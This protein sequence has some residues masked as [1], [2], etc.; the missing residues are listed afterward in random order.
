VRQRGAGEISRDEFFE[1]LSKLQVSGWAGGS[2]V[3][4][5]S[6]QSVPSAAPLAP[7]SATPQL[8]GVDVLGTSVGGH[9]GTLGEPDP[10]PSAPWLAGASPLLTGE[11]ARALLVQGD[12]A[13]KLSAG[14]SGPLLEVSTVLP[15]GPPL[16]RAA[17]GSPADA[18]TTAASAAA[19]A[20]ARA[21][22]CPVPSTQQ[23]SS[24]LADVAP[25]KVHESLPQT[26]GSRAAQAKVPE[27]AGGP[28]Q[29]HVQ[30][31]QAALLAKVTTTT[32]GGWWPPVDNQEVGSP[33]GSDGIA[34]LNDYSS[35]P[36]SPH[37]PQ[38][39]GASQSWTPEGSFVGGH[40]S[41]VSSSFSEFAQRS[42]LWE[43]QR[44]MRCEERRRQKDAKEAAECSFQPATGSRNHRPRTSGDSGSVGSTGGLDA[45]AAAALAARLSRPPL[46]LAPRR[47]NE[48]ARW[49]KAREEEVMRE[50]TFRPDLSQSSRSY[51]LRPSSS[52]TSINMSTCDATSDTRVVAVER[53]SSVGTGEVSEREGRRRDCFYPQTNAVARDMVNARA[54]LQDDVF[55]RLSQPPHNASVSHPPAVHLSQQGELAPTQASMESSISRCRSEASG[56]EISF[57]GFLQRQNFHEECRRER[58]E[59]LESVHAPTLQPEL[60]NRSVRLAER[61]QARLASGGVPEASR[62]RGC[63]GG[64]NGKVHPSWPWPDL[65][66]SFR[67]KITAAAQQRDRRS[68]SELSAGDHK[69]REAKLKRQR[70][71]KKET[72][73]QSFSF[74]P[75]V[76]EF[77]GVQSRLRIQEDPDMYLQRVE[78]E[79][80]QQ[81]KRREAEQRKIIEQEAAECTFKPDV[82][83]APNFVRRMAESYRLVRQLKEKEGRSE[84][85]DGGGV[86]CRPD[87][88]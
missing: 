50:C 33:C 67:P 32:N 87:W 88:R 11:A 16:A 61:R 78:K 39:W 43:L 62:A 53:S 4:D 17:W 18:V 9:A 51:R 34:I 22:M 8:N 25:Q 15:A 12:L 80:T 72:E 54:Y 73:M 21:A 45:H 13:P 84:G 64:G 65:E 79:R 77:C 7:P 6:R 58:L 83:P 41:S 68:F 81:D 59:H 55:T 70:E 76:N 19:A 20:R 2:S 44:S 60:C 47:S 42:E 75:Q 31:V 1:Q 49:E 85:D 27:F 23:F 86:A 48:A 69:R 36:P 3:G 5:A 66:C 74:T 56:A 71:K 82:N 28:L 46:P 29:A 24:T 14:G 40:R 57:L 63:S 10:V 26:P 52:S 35:A 38:P 37:S 30:D